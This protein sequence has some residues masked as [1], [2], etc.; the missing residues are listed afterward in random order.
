MK[1]KSTTSLSGPLALVSKQI[2]KENNCEESQKGLETKTGSKKFLMA[3]ENHT[4]SDSEDDIN[5][6]AKSIALITHQFNKKFGKK[7]LKEGER[8]K[9]EEILKEDFNKNPDS[10]HIVIK[11]VQ[12]ST[13]M[14]QHNN[15]DL[16][17]HFNQG[18]HSHRDT[19]NLKN[20]SQRQVLPLIQQLKMMEDVSDVEN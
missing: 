1:Q 3:E 9:K 4:D 20:R 14:T 16:N 18:I 12:T 11:R 13:I 17:N 6:F 7:Y 2:S 5:A 8:M 10:L 19:S 15:Q